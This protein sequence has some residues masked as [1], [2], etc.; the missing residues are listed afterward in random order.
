VS[1]DRYAAR[2]WAAIAGGL[3]GRLF[4]TLRERRS[5]AYAVL[6]AS[7]QRAGAGLLLTYI[8]TSPDREAEARGAMLAELA[9]FRQEPPSAEETAR[10]TRYLAG[11]AA[12]QRQTGAA[13]AGEIVDAWLAGTGLGELEDPGAAY[14]AVTPEEVHRV[15]EECLVADRRAEG[16]VRTSPSS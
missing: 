11:Q 4:E 2:V 3:G 7:W 6:A 9:R 1:P 10:A 14:L 8:G 5:L 16:V 12:V 15:L 13:V